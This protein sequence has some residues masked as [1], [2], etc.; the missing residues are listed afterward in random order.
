MPRRGLVL[1]AGGHAAIAWETGIVAGAADRGVDLAGADVFVGTSAGAVVAAQISN[2][3]HAADLADRY[4][5]PAGQTAESAPAFDLQQWRVEFVR[6]K[7][8]AKTPAEFLQRIGSMAVSATT[9]SESD[10]RAVVERRLPVHTWPSCVVRIVAVDVE[11]GERTVFDAASG[12]PLVDAVAASSAVPGVWP[13]ATIGGRRYYDG[14]LYSLENADLAAGCDVVVVIALR[15]RVP[16]FVAA[17]LDAAVE[18]LRRAGAR[19]EIVHP[20]E[21]TEAAFASVGG[22]LLDPRVRPAAVRA[23]REQ[24]HQIASQLAAIW[25]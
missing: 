5:N 16:S 3:V 22:N 8:G 6:A 21:A 2:G 19:V 11:T 25:A 1:G 18:G 10:R 15:P 20:D 24:A 13:T 7:E 23:G 17:P 12:A 9:I 4:A 14:G